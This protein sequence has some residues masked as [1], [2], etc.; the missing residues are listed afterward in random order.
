MDA[1]R[2]ILFVDD[3]PELL[4][5]LKEE[6]S[7]CETLTAENG[8]EGLKIALSQKPDLIISDVNMPVLD[9]LS[10][11]EKIRSAGLNL[12]VI[13]M[14]A[15]S[16]TQKIRKAWA[17]GAFDFLEKPVD[18]E[19]LKKLANN[20]FQ[21]G[22]NFIEQNANDLTVVRLSL[23]KSVLSQLTAQAHAQGLTIEEWL[24][25]TLASPQKKSA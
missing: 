8:S 7:H 17:L 23:K 20:A 2:K 1:K 5:I 22:A 16:D 14:T 24:E 18:F 25:A 9:G 10:M 15:F 4:A 11:L 13:I 21:F 19:A 12:P 6:F 3:E